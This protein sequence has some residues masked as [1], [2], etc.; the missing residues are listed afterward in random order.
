MLMAALPRPVRAQSVGASESTEVG[1]FENPS[2]VPANSQDATVW[3]ASGEV[4]MWWTKPGPAPVP[5]ATTFPPSRRT[6]P[7]PSV[8]G[9]LG[10]T[11][12]VVVLGGAP[13]DDPVQV[14]G[15]FTL[16]RWLDFDSNLGTEASFLFL[17]PAN[18]SDTV[19]S[20]GAFYLTNPYLAVASGSQTN[21]S[22]I[23][24]SGVI[25]T[26]PNGSFGLA[27]LT[28]N[29]QVY[30]AEWNALWSAP[31]A[32]G[33]S[34]Q[35]LGG[36]RFFNLDE[37]LALTTMKSNRTLFSGQ[38][39]NTTDKFQTQNFFNGGQLGLNGEWSSGGWFFGTTFKL[40]AGS[41]HEEL[42]IL[43]TTTTNTGRGLHT[44]IPVTTVPGGIYAQPTNIGEYSH[45]RFALLPEVAVRMGVQMTPRVR[46]FVGYNFLYLSSVVRPGNQIDGGINP[47]QLVSATGVPTGPLV[48]PARPTPLFEESKFWAQG[49]TFGGEFTW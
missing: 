4:L 48:G 2:L 44:K 19:T 42:E 41:T 20:T 17:S 31:Q 12:T 43:G 25:G 13:I 49:L 30:G 1:R 18:T 38:F 11:G 27:T 23:L 29:R 3:W 46:Y 10:E 22:N 14:G 5:L 35:L 47:T 40:A 21:T 33:F 7:V 39:M 8:V 37:Q 45:D 34:W 6:G 36:Y 24:M 16:G 28:S 15:R 26:R 9:A 32:N